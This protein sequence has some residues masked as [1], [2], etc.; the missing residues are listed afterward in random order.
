MAKNEMEEFIESIISAAKDNGVEITPITPL[1]VPFTAEDI[2]DVL[3]GSFKTFTDIINKVD[4]KS[5]APVPKNPTQNKEKKTT[6]GTILKFTDFFKTQN[7]NVVDKHIIILDIDG[8]VTHSIV[9]T[10]LTK[11]FD[12][13][14]S[15]VKDDDTKFYKYLQNTVISINGSIYDYDILK[16]YQAY[17]DYKVHEEQVKEE[18]QL[19]IKAEKEKEY[20]ELISRLHT[21]EQEYPEFNTKNPW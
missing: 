4:E 8:N 3:S 1:N 7:L 6:N 15:Y 11:Y 18:E 20:M 14:W 10:E 5:E 19:R 16:V 2:A 12:S 17:V 9:D 21:L 13:V